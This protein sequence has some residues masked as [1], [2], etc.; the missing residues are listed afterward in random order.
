MAN[1][2]NDGAW[3]SASA[4]TPSSVRGDPVAVDERFADA[5]LSMD[6]LGVGRAN[7]VN[8]GGFVVGSLGGGSLE[9]AAYWNNGAVNRITATTAGGASMTTAFRVN[10]AGFAVGNGTDPNMLSRNVGLLYNI[11]NGMLTEVPAPWRQ[12]HDRVRHQRERLRGQ[13]EL[14]QP[15]RLDAVHL[16]RRSRRGQE[17]PLP[18]GASARS[19]GCELR[20]VGGRHREWAVRGAVPVRR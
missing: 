9:V 15:V 1:G 14:V 16:E 17:I 2:A 5:A 4:R 12:R 18:A 6:G 19:H 8:D 11:N 20:R 10:N 3:W 13:F 7:D